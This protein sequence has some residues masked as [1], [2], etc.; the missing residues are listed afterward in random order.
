MDSHTD[1]GRREQGDE[2]AARAE[3]EA[4][5]ERNG[6]LRCASGETDGAEMEVEERSIAAMEQALTPMQL[7]AI[8]LILTG[9]SLASIAR[10][11]KV[12]R[13]TVFRWRQ[14]KAFSTVL[15]FRQEAVFQQAQDRLR[16]TLVKAVREVQ[17]DLE[18]RHQIDRLRTA[19][20]L[21]PYVGSPKLW[22]EEPKRPPVSD[23]ARRELAGKEAG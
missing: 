17:Q 2:D 21:L 19:F 9:R 8:G 18:S 12:G 22:P 5:M 14:Q 1:A 11:L 13:T 15:R 7:R 10:T 4:E 6:A 20:R 3:M 16:A 23:A